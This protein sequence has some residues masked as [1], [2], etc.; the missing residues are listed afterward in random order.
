MM[1][2]IV[3]DGW[4]GSV[5]GRPTTEGLSMTH[6]N[7]KLG[8]LVIH[9]SHKSKPHFHLCAGQIPTLCQVH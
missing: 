6:D 8:Q 7:L 4:Q 9:V 1:P 3:Y 2:F 5:A